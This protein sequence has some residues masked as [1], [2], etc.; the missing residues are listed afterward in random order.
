MYVYI[1]TAKIFLLLQLFKF[2]LMFL[3]KF[4]PF[5]RKNIF[6]LSGLPFTCC[7]PS[8]TFL[9]LPLFNLV[10]FLKLNVSRG[11]ISRFYCLG[12]LG[13]LIFYV[14]QSRFT[15]GAQ[16]NKRVFQRIFTLQM[17]WTLI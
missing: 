7:I 10:W 3:I 15:I 13:G 8:P 17:K 4:C 12:H 14:D 2:S 11:I 9:R 6:L 1:V 5:P 16:E